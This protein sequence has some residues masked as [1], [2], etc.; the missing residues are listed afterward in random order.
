MSGTS[1]LSDE[2]LVHS[3]LAQERELVAARFKHS[4]NTLEDT[5]TLRRLR[6][7]IARLH[8][9]ARARE[10]ENGLPKGRLL[11]EHRA[12]FSTSSDAA[13]EA[14]APKGGFLSGVVDKLTGKD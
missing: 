9:S 13:A 1:E 8:T 3:L 11:H 14:D 7:N 6:R 4:L 2:Q 10:R 5:S 12:S